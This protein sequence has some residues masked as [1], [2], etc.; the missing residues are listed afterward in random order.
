M[1][2]IAK[3]SRQWLAWIALSILLLASL[4]LLSSSLAPSHALAPEDVAQ[5]ELAL[6]KVA[7][8]LE[9]TA[10]DLVTY[11]VT[12]SNS[13]P[14]S[15]TV[16]AITDTLDAPL[17]FA[18]M[19]AASDVVTPPQV[20]D[21]TLTW[22]GPFTVPSGSELTLLYQVQTAGSFDA[23]QACNG[24]AIGTA[25]PAPDP[26]EACVDVAGKTHT[27]YVPQVYQDFAFGW[28]SVTKSVSSQLVE[29]D[30]DAELVYTVTIVNEGD[31]AGTLQTISDTLPAGV[32]FAG[33]AAG[34][35]VAAN[36]A[37]TTGTIVWSGNWPMAPGERLDVVYRVV[38][39]VPV[40]EHTNQVAVAASQLGVPLQPA[41]ATFTAEPGI[42]LEEN[43]NDPSA[44]LSR[45]T[46][47]MNYWRLEEDQWRWEE[48]D[49][50]GGSGAATQ[51]C[52]L[53]G[54]KVAE[55]ALLMYLGPG[56]Q[57][58]T[59]YRVETKM[60]LRGG[61]N[62]KDGVVKIIEN[63]GYPVGLWVRGQY[64]DVGKEDTAGWVTGYYIIVGG[65][66][67][68]DTMF[69][70]LS[71]L[72]TLTDCWDLACVNTQ[73]LYDFNNPHGLRQVELNQSFKRYTWY[74]LAVEVR[75]NNIKI[76]F[77]NELVMD[78]TDEKEPFLEGTI[79]FKTYKS[80]TVSFDDVI[81]TPLH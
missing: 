70:R 72:Q 40:G 11:T 18:G 56:A 44:R 41:G 39:N 65:K 47:F 59:D 10:G 42:L 5:A 50:V 51:D 66:P 14:V 75:G 36:P 33:M 38:A 35:E 15:A 61:V 21:D 78:Y 28:L 7:S 81:V 43:F 67:T 17:T 60:L 1:N 48:H 63:G 79:G 49:G 55:D 27:A 6:E 52:W 25:V 74:T 45:W 69:I 57:Q 9:V 73:N 16:E 76:Y 23:Y 71:Q 24:V 3:D 4:L 77:D 30:I 31:T 46:R 12:V 37:G 32:T 64:K 54:K 58:W 13:G 26:A 2:E 53:G 20:A 19:L 68:E 62:E 29:A 34:S 22:T 80:K 8:P